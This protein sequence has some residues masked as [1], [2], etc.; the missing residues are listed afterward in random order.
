MNQIPNRRS[1]AN[2]FES[3][4]DKRGPLFGLADLGYCG[5]YPSDGFHRYSLNPLD[6]VHPKFGFRIARFKNAFHNKSA[7]VY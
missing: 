7:R 1:N 3:I 6:S 2:P 4:T 5:L